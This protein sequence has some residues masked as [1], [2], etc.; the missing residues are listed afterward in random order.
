[1]EDIDPVIKDRH[2]FK[3]ACG[4]YV[5][6]IGIIDYLTEF[7]WPKKME[8]FYKIN[9]KNVKEYNLSAVNP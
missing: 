3:S 8:S 6:H 9:F 5:Y 7:T 4:K 1:M 2:R